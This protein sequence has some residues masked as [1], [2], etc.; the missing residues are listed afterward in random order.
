MTTTTSTTI[1]RDTDERVDT[2][3]LDMLDDE[4][5]HGACRICWPRPIGLGQRFI[6]WCGVPAVWFRDAHGKIPPDSCPDCLARKTCLR[7]GATLHDQRG[8]P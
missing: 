1:S 6:A 3:D 7:C 5:Y 4:R 2:S 8:R